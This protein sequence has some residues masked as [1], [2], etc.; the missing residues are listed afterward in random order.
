MRYYY[1]KIEF[2]D[3]CLDN[4]NIRLLNEILNVINNNPHLLK[5]ILSGL[6]QKD[7]LLLKEILGGNKGDSGIN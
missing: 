7:Q 6:S 1:Q 5:D 3:D 2:L 4:Y